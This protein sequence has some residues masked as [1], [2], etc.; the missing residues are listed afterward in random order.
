MNGEQRQGVQQFIVPDWPAPASVR[1]LVTTRAGG[2]SRG[3]YCSFNLGAHVG[4]DPAH[5]RENRARLRAVLPAD[6]VWLEQVHGSDV[7]DAARAAPGTRADGAYTRSRGVICAVLTADCLPIFLCDRAGTEVALL[8]A[9]W[10]G[11]ARGVIEQGLAALRAPPEDRLAWLGPAIGPPAYEVGG[12][13]RDAFV[14]RRPEAAVAF[15]PARRG[16]WYLDLYALARQRL[17]ALG[18]RAIHG[19]RY[20]TASQP[21]LF[22]SHRRDGATGRMASLIWL[23]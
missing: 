3:A 2:V 7:V 1:A 17:E 14:S 10:R 15:A 13:V 19:G 20:C 9:G 12:E 6:P 21:E 8:H 16:K 22:F 4:D 11:L 18:V 23:A 5:V